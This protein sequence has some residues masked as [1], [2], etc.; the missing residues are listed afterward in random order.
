M[1]FSMHSNA[2][3]SVWH[4]SRTTSGRSKA[5][6]RAR[7]RSAFCLVSTGKC[8]GVPGGKLRT[9]STKARISS[10]VNGRFGTLPK[11]ENLIH[12]IDS[13]FSTLFRICFA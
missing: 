3:A 5:Y 7:K 8:T 11:V 9:K 6:E 1:P 4:D 10:S 2:R 12:G 13:P